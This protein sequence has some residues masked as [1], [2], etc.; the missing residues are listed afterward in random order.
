MATKTVSNKELNEKVDKLTEILAAFM[1]NQQIE[2]VL[3]KK[4]GRPA[5]LTHTPIGDGKKPRGYRENSPIVDEILPEPQIARKRRGGWENNF[6]DERKEHLDDSIFDKKVA[7]LP[8]VDKGVRK[9][10]IIKSTCSGCQKV[11]NVPT[12]FVMSDPETRERYHT[13]Q[14]CL[15]SKLGK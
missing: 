4:R 3:P 7:V 2:E 5:K 8:P 10:A 9:S 15:K 14:K 12:Q 1:Q 13:C 6:V 11:E